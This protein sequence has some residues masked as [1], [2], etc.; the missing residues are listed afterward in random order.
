MTRIPL[1]PA[2]VL[3]AAL[4]CAILAAPVSA[5]DK[6]IAVLKNSKGKEVG[7]V[8]CSPNRTPWP[9]PLFVGQYSATPGPQYQVTGRIAGVRIYQRALSAEYVAERMAAGRPQ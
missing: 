3:A 1:W 2:S 5:A 7:K 9:G 8:A 4:T 6:A